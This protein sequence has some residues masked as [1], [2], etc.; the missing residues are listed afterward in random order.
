MPE[1][2]ASRPLP[3]LRLPLSCTL[4][5]PERQAPVRSYALLGRYVSLNR[6]PY[7]NAHYPIDAYHK[8][9]CSSCLCY[10]RVAARRPG[11]R[12]AH[13]LELIARKYM[14]F[15]ELLSLLTALPMCRGAET[16]ERMRLTR[17]S[18]RLYSAAT[19]SLALSDSQCPGRLRAEFI[20]KSRLAQFYLTL[21]RRLVYS[22]S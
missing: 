1:R 21:R 6:T 10:I 8:V 19:A 2:Q 7:Y 15:H 4:R 12:S 20:C 11:A 22:S 17:F 9:W 5:V 13:I 16:I 14:Q 18:L 3:A